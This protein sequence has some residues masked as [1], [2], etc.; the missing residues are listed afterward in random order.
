MRHVEK[1]T[2]K[3]SAGEQRV[4]VRLEEGRKEPLPP[5][6]VLVTWG[7]VHV[8]AYLTQHEEA[9]MWPGM[10]PKPITGGAVSTVS[11][12]CQDHRSTG[13]ACRRARW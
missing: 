9:G 13:G 2:T 7:Y 12:T 3:S 5:S 1:E 6:S 4:M 11:G 10:Y 8:H